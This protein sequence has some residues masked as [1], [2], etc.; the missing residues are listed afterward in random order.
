VL[1]WKDAQKS[2]KVILRAGPGEQWGF[3]GFIDLE[4]STYGKYIEEFY[5]V[6]LSDQSNLQKA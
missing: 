3:N 1:G 4:L 6:E 2:V 5:T